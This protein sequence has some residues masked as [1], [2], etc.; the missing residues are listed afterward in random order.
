MNPEAPLAEMVMVPLFVQFAAVAEPDT[1]IVMPVQG[2]VGP[3][4]GLL[5]EQEIKLA[6]PSRAIIIKHSRDIF[7]DIEVVL[8]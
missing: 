8:D 4:S 5:F 7:L 1:A 2:F 6:E 3:G